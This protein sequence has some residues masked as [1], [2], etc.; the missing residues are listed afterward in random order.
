M[1]KQLGLDLPSKAALGRDDFFISPANAIAVATLENWQN[2]PNRKLVLAGP[3]G[4]GKTH[5]THVWATETGAM[6][7]AATDLAGI[8]VEDTASASC[9]AIEDIPDI[10]GNPNVERALF[11]LHNLVLA[12]NGTLLLTGDTAPSRWPLDLQDLASRMQGTS[13][14][15]LEP[16]D[17]QLLSAVLLKL[18][19]DRQL[20]PKHTVISYL[21]A[22]MDRSFD[23]A[24]RVVAEMDRLALA[25]RRKLNRGLASDVLDILRDP[26]T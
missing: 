5:L 8:P 12:Q 10:A 11:H 20:T 6:V 21:I 15:A 26:S 22:N 16:P 13:V 1:A 17:D 19:A 2:W 4:S 18:F 25:D 9:I 3:R 24:G 7:I 14:V 23:M